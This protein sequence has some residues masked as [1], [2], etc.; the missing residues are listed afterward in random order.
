LQG[1]KAA[2]GAASEIGQAYIKN[3]GELGKAYLKNP[4]PIPL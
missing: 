2:T 1:F 4:I 3:A